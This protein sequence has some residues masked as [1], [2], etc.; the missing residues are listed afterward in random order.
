MTVE[1]LTY[2]RMTIYVLSGRGDEAR[3][4]FRG[5]FRRLMA[6]ASSRIVRT[7]KSGAFGFSFV[8]MLCWEGYFRIAG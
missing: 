4:V 8:A 6:T 7:E 5:L 2:P 3:S 1:L